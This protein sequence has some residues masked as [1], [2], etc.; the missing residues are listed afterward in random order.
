MNI[1]CKQT[2]QKTT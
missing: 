1:K 2:R